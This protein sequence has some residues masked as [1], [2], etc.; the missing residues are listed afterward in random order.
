[1]NCAGAFA[2]KLHPLLLRSVVAEFADATVSFGIEGGDSLA[3]LGKG[4]KVPSAFKAIVTI[5][6]SRVAFES[7]TKNSIAGQTTTVYEIRA[8]QALPRRAPFGGSEPWAPNRPE[9]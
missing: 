4:T 8:S 9:G 2:N 7:S 3:R 6:G 5:A 1:M